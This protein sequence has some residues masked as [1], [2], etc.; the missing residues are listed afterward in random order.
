[1]T[2]SDNFTARAA[3]WSAAHRRLVVRGW[4]GFVLLAV[5]LGSTVGM[6]T[7]SQIESE[8]GQSRRADQIQA[9]QFPRER[10]GEEVLVENPRGPL[11]TAGDRAIGEVVARLSKLGTVAAI[12]SPLVP[13]NAGQI[14]RDGHAAL[15]TF[16]IAGD[17]STAQNRVGAALA[18]TAAV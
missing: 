3:R 11:G 2:E 18:A 1:M 12:G 17:P 13:A 7:L 8:N 5:V 14:S 16:Q 6:V 10:A 4:L 9:Q 15:V